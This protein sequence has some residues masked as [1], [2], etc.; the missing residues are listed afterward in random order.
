LTLIVVAA[1]VIRTGKEEK[2]LMD[3]FGNVYMIYSKNTG[4]FFPLLK[5]KK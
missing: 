5:L 1:L 2:K 3:R 4:R